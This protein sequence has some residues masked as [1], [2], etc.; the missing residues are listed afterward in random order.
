MKTLAAVYG[1]LK[2]GDQ[3]ENWGADALIQHPQQLKQ[4]IKDQ[5]CH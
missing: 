4:W 3:P 2:E 5:L 1:Y